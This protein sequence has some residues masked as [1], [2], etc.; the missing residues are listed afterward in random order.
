MLTLR[1]AAFALLPLL[2]S[3]TQAAPPATTTPAFAPTRFSVVVEGR[4]PDVILIPG[5]AS[6][7]GV[8]DGARAALG[9]RYR[10]H[11]VELNGF[12]G[13]PAGVNAAG[14]V[15][16]PAVDELARYIAV[17]R[18]ARPAVVGHSMGGLMG[19]MLARAHPDAIGKLMVVDA[20]PFIG[21]LFAPNAT[22]EAIAPRA[23]AMRDTMLAAPSRPKAVGAP[24]PAV[25][26]MSITAA[27]A[28]TV[29]RWS[30]AAD[31]RAVARAMYDDM[32]TD[33]RPDLSKLRA[34]VTM[35]Y[36]YSA[37]SV[38]AERAKALYEGAYRGTP[39]L[40]FVPVAESFHFIM[41][42]QPAIFAAELKTFLGDAR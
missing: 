11:L 40:R 25:P 37:K 15:L 6:P 30:A 13:A 5:L 38:G 26:G 29:A 19:L 33:V 9:G 17:N 20:L 4:G 41:L 22:V 14:P 35:L 27:G 31:P 28:A 3:Q 2:V 36:P 24:P 23:A 8:W 18:L 12:G 21:T 39:K 16:V 34:P 1:L 42:D 10:L 32:V 7:R